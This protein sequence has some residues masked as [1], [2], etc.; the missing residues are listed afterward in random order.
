M[1]LVVVVI[2]V[3]VI[4]VAAGGMDGEDWMGQRSDRRYYL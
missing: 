3:A 1:K 4:V 2:V